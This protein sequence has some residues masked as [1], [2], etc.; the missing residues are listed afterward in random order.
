MSTPTEK[1]N[2]QL[3]YTVLQQLH[4]DVTDIYGKKADAVIEMKLKEISAHYSNLRD[5]KLAPIDYSPPE[6]R[7]AYVFSYVAAHADFVYQMLNTTQKHLGK[8]IV[9]KE[10]LVV[11]CL[12]GGPGSEL[13]GLLQ[14]LSEDEDSALETVT[15]YLCDREQAWADCWTEI[16]EEVPGAMRLNANFQPLDVTDP[17]SWSKQKKFLSADLF[18]MSYFASEIAR[19]DAAADAFWSELAEKSKKGALM[20]IVDNAHTYFSEFINE[21][22]ITNHWKQL[23]NGQVNLTP[24]GREQKSDLKD[25][26]TRYGRSPKLRGNIEY[27][28]LRRK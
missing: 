28:V 21:K 16:G 7:Y 19:L 18:I 9:K 5:E 15:A 8:E 1:T 24:S 17:I 20:L 26:L 14:Y 13:V 27:W 4:Q 3:V 11:T 12:G 23:E 22:I 25:Y 6:T 10:K 2:F